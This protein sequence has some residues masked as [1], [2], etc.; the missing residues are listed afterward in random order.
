MPAKTPARSAARAESKVQPYRLEVKFGLLERLE[1]T[2]FKPPAIVRVRLQ[3]QHLC[4][5]SKL[6]RPLRE[7][8]RIW[9]ERARE[10][11][12]HSKEIEWH[13][14]PQARTRAPIVWQKKPPPTSSSTSTTPSTG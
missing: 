7:K 11:I 5:R 2:L 12:L 14:P 13:N 8:V 1:Q 10:S 6:H 9:H 3:S 4:G